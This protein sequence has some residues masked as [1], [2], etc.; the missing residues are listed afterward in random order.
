MPSAST[1]VRYDGSACLNVR[2][3]TAA[4]EA[5][6]G[7]APNNEPLRWSDLSSVLW[8]VETCVTSK[9]LY[10]DGTV[11]KKTT[12]RALED[13]GRF[14]QKH[15]LEGLKVSAIAFSDPRETLDA[16]HD[17]IEESRLD[18][19][20]FKLDTTADKPLD[21]AE[22][23]EFV[24]Q[25]GV[26]LSLP[27][28]RREDLALTWVADAFRGSKCLAGLIAT[29]E[30]ALR[31][32]RVL[33]DRH[34]DQG[35]LV[36]GALINRFRLNYVNQL[37]AYRR[38]A[39][40]PD[41]N[42]E[43]LTREHHRLFKDYFLERVVKKLKKD[44]DEPNVLVENMTAENPLP[45]I[46]LFA[47]MATRAKGRPAAIL[48]TAF[49]AFRQDDALMRVIWRNTKGGIAIKKAQG[50]DAES[51]ILH[52]FYDRYKELAKEAEGIKVL[53]SSGRKSRTYLVPAVLKGLAKAV[54]A[55]LGLGGVCEVVYSV[56]RATAEEASIPFLSDHLL[57]AGC[58]SHISQYKSLKWDFEQDDAVK[59]SLGRL[60]EHVEQVFGRPLERMA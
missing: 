34:P 28:S 41:P 16:A 23:E 24:R 37:A 8:F 33:Y 36:T 49:Q 52:F 19:E 12:E 32:A 57:G 35:P 4:C 3:I 48:E 22:H 25:L 30:P 58:D 6:A 7:A 47:L 53:M 31:T 1:A 38:G 5:L 29:G 18:L 27:E 59:R 42:F 40:V 13:V 14:K 21:Q 2:S 56:L 26:A 54:P 39:Y 45:P 20:S 60:G 51:E 15:D 44:A 17:A 43:N 50:A 11:P 9:E 10:F 55:A 46:G